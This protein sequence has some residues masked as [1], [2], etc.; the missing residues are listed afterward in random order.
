MSTA[1]APVGDR[2]SILSSVTLS[3]VGSAGLSEWLGTCS[4][5]RFKWTSVTLHCGLGQA[6]SLV[7]PPTGGA[8]TKAAM[9]ES[10]GGKPAMPS[11]SRH[12]KKPAAAFQG[13]LRRAEA[14]S[15]SADVELERWGKPASKDIS[16]LRP[17]SRGSW[18]IA[19]LS[20]ERKSPS[21]EGT[22]EIALS[23]SAIPSTGSSSSCISIGRGGAVYS[24]GTAS[25]ALVGAG[26]G[27]CCLAKSSNTWAIWAFRA[28]M[29]LAWV[30]HLTRLA[31]WSGE[32]ERRHGLC[33]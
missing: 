6:G 18:R 7:K 22:K 26:L 12:P 14:L 3:R 23:S 21:H 17:A 9:V 28:I 33:S 16:E 25:D 30:E 1:S 31:G 15:T 10:T 4:V 11:F 32:G 27:A 5:A 13:M 19:P 29:S 2:F 20:S 8:L 24:A